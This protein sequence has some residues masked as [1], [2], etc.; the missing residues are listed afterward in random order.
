[1]EFSHDAL[2]DNSFEGKRGAQFSYGMKAHNDLIKVRGKDFRAE[3][4]KKKRGTYRGGQID[5]GSHS[6]KFV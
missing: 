2:R 4:T 1:V 6:I 3:K 5:M